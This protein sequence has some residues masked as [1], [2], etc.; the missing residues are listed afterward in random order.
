MQLDRRSMGRAALGLAAG[1]LLP[2]PA[3]AVYTTPFGPKAPWNVPVA[4]LAP[5]PQSNSYRDRF[6]N[7]AS[8]RPGNINLTFEGYTYPVYDVRRA[9]GL[10]PVRNHRLGQPERQDDSLELELESGQRQ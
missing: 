3:L 10:Y 2:A 4:G 8:D 7:G 1:A 5:H 6:W 9:A